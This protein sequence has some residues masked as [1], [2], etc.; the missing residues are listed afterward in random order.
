[1]TG[2]RDPRSE[3]EGP[4]REDGAGAAVLA[5]GSGDEKPE[6]QVEDEHHLDGPPLADP[7]GFRLRGDPPRVMRLSRQA[8]ATLGA[9]GALAVGGSLPFA[10][11]SRD[12]AA[13][14]EPYNTD[15]RPGTEKE[16]GRGSCRDRRV[17]N[18]E[19]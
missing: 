5:E 9:V 8:M 12:K 6:L 2:D 16:I 3:G 14:E 7:A 17:T 10:L 11:H 1:M 18:R 4:E 19:I 13:P 15:S